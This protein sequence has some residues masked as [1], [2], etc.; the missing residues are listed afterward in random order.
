MA[1]RAPQMKT[2]HLLPL[3]MLMRGQMP[4]CQM[5]RSAVRAGYLQHNGLWASWP[6]HVLRQMVTAGRQC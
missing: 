2:S 4:T 5:M 1:M 3:P 6:I